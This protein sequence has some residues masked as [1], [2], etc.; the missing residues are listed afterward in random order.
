MNQ[1]VIADIKLCIG[2]RTCEIACVMA[3]RD[4]DA[5]PLSAENFTPRLKV[6]KTFNISAPIL[7][8]QCEN[9]PCLNACP[10]DAIHN[11]D[12]SVQVIQSRCIGCKSCMVACPYGAMEVVA[13]HSHDAARPQ[14][15]QANKCDLCH[16]RGEGPACVEVCPTGALTLIKPA[17]LQAMQQE[18]QLRAACGTTPNLRS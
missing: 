12:G 13:S 8:R 17:D 2:C 5:L 14:R 1:F 9:A 18:R 16:G 4:D 6:M 10:N 3:H 11:Q 15:V 7:C